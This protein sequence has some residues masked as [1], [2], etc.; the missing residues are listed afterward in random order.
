MT[1]INK[2][3]SLLSTAGAFV[4]QQYLANTLMTQMVITKVHL[5]TMH[6]I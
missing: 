6:S 5:L 1:A 4:I 3:T 2:V